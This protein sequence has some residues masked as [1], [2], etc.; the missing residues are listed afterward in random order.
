M[1]IYDVKNGL[2]HKSSFY[3]LKSQSSWEKVGSSYLI[4]SIEASFLGKG[5]YVEEIAENDA[6]AIRF[7]G[8]KMGSKMLYGNNIDVGQKININNAK[9]YYEV[10]GSGE[11]LLL[12]HGN[13]E[14]INS[15]REQIEPLSKYLK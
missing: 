15:F 7:L 9:L 6:L 5:D 10:Y 4:A 14:G 8:K 13:N 2:P 12:L 1:N 11:P 3:R